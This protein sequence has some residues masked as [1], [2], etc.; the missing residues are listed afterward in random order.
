MKYKHPRKSGTS[1][2]SEAIGDMLRDYNLAGKFDEKR[3]IESWGKVMGKVVANRTT[4][5]Y[6]KNSVLFVEVSSAPLRNEL[7]MSKSKVLAL[8]NKEVGEGIVNEVIF[9]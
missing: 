8:I 2:L 9:Y 3:L 4:K 1:T 7:N 5:I 6:I